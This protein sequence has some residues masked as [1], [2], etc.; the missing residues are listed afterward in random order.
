MVPK[1]VHNGELRNVISNQN[2]WHFGKLL[3][4]W[5]ENF[6]QF[7]LFLGNIDCR[8][9]ENSEQKRCYQLNF[10]CSIFHML[11][12][13]IL[14]LS[15]VELYIL[16][17]NALIFNSLHSHGLLLDIGYHIPLILLTSTKSMIVMSHNAWACFS[18]SSA[19]MAENRRCSNLVFLATMSSGR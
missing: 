16:L 18:L 3:A 2:I 7:L 10:W 11:H 5:T 12:Y 17:I 6:G 1:V 14:Y 4:I 13:F 9:G 8:L 15:V 19:F